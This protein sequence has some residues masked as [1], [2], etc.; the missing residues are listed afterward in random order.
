MNDTA[1]YEYI[2]VGSGAGGGTLAARL[3]E[4]GH[5]VL[6]LESGSDPV[7]AGNAPRLP[8]EYQVPAFHP[9]STENEAMRWDFFVRHYSSD[10]R[11]R[12]D[13][14]FTRT[15]QGETV[16]GVLYPRASCLG[17]CTAHNAMI[18]VYPHNQDW[19]HIAQLTGDPS[20]R[21]SAMREHFQRLENCHHRPLQRFLARFG[22]NPS[23]HGFKGWLHVEKAVPEAVI[24]DLSLVR[25]IVKSA[26]QAFKSLGETLKRIRWQLL[27]VGDPNDWRLVRDAAIGLRYPPLTTRK[28]RRNGTRERLLDVQKRYPDRLHIELDALVTR[29]L[30]DD[31][32]RAFGVEYIKGAGLYRASTVPR[33]PVSEPHHVRASREVILAGGAFNTPQLLMLSGIGPRKPLEA[34]DIPVR[35]ELPGVGR[36]LQ[37]RYEVGVVNR[38]NFDCWEVLEGARYAKGDPQYEQWAKGKTGVYCTNGAVLAVIKKSLRQRP[39][40]DLFC[41]SLLAPFRGYFPG[42]S[43]LIVEHLNYL[44]W[45][46]LKA[47][48]NNSAGYVT[49]RSKDPADTP[50]INFRYFEEGNDTRGEDLQSVVEGI[51][52]VR[53]LAQPLKDAGLIAEEELPGDAVQS[54]EQL[55][56]F[57]MNHAW[58]HHASC[59]CPIGADDDP[60]A[61]LDSAFR[62]RGVSHLRVVDASIFPKIP[63][64]FIVTSIYVA[65]E[66]AAQ[67]ILRDAVAAE[68]QMVRGA[69]QVM[70]GEDR[71]ATV[72]AMVTPR[73]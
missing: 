52:F 15:Y 57:V 62:V 22:I 4:E 44:T 18:T 11:Q 8:E 68:A 65:A 5:K 14:K 12:Q 7:A 27:G 46:V 69:G 24:D 73:R 55:K 50:L 23:R 32:L 30:I 63:G 61:V 45:A 17:G 59:T 48:T 10:V 3:A 53:H 39:L 19:D 72:E 20:W 13:P 29:V 66:K 51:K 2:V 38:M 35:V 26:D 41:F 43:Q 31:Q 49:L 36:N 71:A 16:D 67:V 9:R 42:Y 1:D 40:P 37:D 60:M 6:V 47:H 25:S 54:D 70:A 33:S 56:E 21:A 58:G 34:L 28:H 64:F